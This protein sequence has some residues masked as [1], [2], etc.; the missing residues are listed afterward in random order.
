MI[1]KKTTT[2][3]RTMIATMTATMTATNM[4]NLNLFLSARIYSKEKYKTIKG[5][6]DK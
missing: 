2:T 4:C 5:R 3:I 6:I 1:R